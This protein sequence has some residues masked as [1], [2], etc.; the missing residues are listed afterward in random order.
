MSDTIKYRF[1]MFFCLIICGLQPKEKELPATKDHQPAAT[2]Q[3]SY[4]PKKATREQRL[5]EKG[6]RSVRYDR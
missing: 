6:V 1:I 3:V 2:E 4:A 5:R